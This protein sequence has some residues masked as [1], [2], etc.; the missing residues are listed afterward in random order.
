VTRE[1]VESVLV[2]L[3]EADT[4]PDDGDDPTFEAPWQARAFALTVALRR[5]E[6]FP[7][8]AFQKRLIDAVAAVE[9]DDEAS[10]YEAWLDAIEG[11][12]LAEGVLGREELAERVAAF[13]R[14]DRDAGEFVV[15]DHGHHL[16]DHDHAHDQD[17]RRSE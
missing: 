6:A 5:N 9:T 4:V 1:H 10:Y 11:L 13:E 3:R 8:E 7:W 12:L 2:A 14:G 17:N 15:G 16:G